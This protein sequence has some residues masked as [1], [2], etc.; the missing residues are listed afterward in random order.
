MDR[1]FESE[2]EKAERMSVSVCQYD[3]LKLV[4]HR[5]VELGI[6]RYAHW[7]DGTQ[8]VGT[9]GNSIQK[10]M[11]DLDADMDLKCQHPQYRDTDGVEYC[12]RCG[13]CK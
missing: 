5:G 9:C 13:R 12:T 10:A 6:R 1:Q 11:Q 7:K 4:L 3:L 8:Y 2:I